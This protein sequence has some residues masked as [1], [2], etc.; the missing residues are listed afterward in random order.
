MDNIA[1]AHREAMNS[2]IFDLAEGRMAEGGFTEEETKLLTTL[3]KGMGLIDEATATAMDGLNETVSNFN[4][5][6][7]VGKAIEDILGYSLALDG[8]PTVI[9]IQQQIGRLAEQTSRAF[10]PGVP[11]RYTAGMAGV[12]DRYH[13]LEII[14]ARRALVPPEISVGL[15]TTQQYLRDTRSDVEELGLAYDELPDEVLTT[16]EIENQNDLFTALYGLRNL[17]AQIEGRHRIDF[18]I[19]PVSGGGGMG[20]GTPPA[21]PNIAEQWSG[22]GGGTETT[23]ERMPGGA[24][25]QQVAGGGPTQNFNLTVNTTRELFSV[26]HEFEVMSAMGGQ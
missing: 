7:N 15:S 18:Q 16:I 6:G 1:A 17:V 4:R 10:D 14:A 8:I 24:P 21:G 22:G 13:Q 11:E 2:I 3:A 25:M 19:A 12:Q 20:G 5:D 9:P 26:R 23:T